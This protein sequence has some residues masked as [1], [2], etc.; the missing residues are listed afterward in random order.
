MKPF[1][2][3]CRLFALAS[4]VLVASCT[5]TEQIFLEEDGTG[6]YNLAFDGSGMMAMMDDM[7]NAADSTAQDDASDAEKEMDST[8]VFKDMLVRL[9]DSIAQL[10]PKEQEAMKALE[11]YTMNIQM[12]EKNK[13]MLFS[14]ERSFTDLDELTNGFKDFQKAMSINDSTQ[15][16]AN[17]PFNGFGQNSEVTYTFR[18]NTFT[19]SAKVP[20][21]EELGISEEEM[22]SMDMMMGAT[23][24]KVE[25]HFPRKI[26]TTSL[27]GAQI[28]PN[29]KILTFEL[30]MK[31]VMQR[32]DTLNFEV[33]LEKK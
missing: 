14:L 23:T 3:F 33:Q 4:L 31:D 10:D 13:K 26:K 22:Q 18:K 27:Q 19:R 5:L 9:Q 6:Y 1:A 25:Y 21:A 32:P 28:S 30:S 2:V 7:G 17:N 11:P 12:S 20:E 16:Q 8:I 24:Y 15:S 29:G